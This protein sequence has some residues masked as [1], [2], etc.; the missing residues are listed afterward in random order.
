MLDEEFEDVGDEP[1][2]LEADEI[3]DELNGDE[4]DDGNPDADAGEPG[5]D[6]DPEGEQPQGNAKPAAPANAWDAALKAAGEMDEEPEGDDDEDDASGKPKSDA[7]KEKDGEQA[8]KP[9]AK[10]RYTIADANGDEYEIDW[11]KGAKISFKGDGKQVQVQSLDELVDL[12]QKGAAFDRVSSSAGQLK[13][14]VGTLEQQLDEQRTQ[15]EETLLK[16]CFDKEAFQAVRKSIAKYR[17]PDVR[18]AARK[19]RAHDADQERKKKDQSTEAQQKVDEFWDGIRSEYREQITAEDS[20]FPLLDEDDEGAV[21]ELFYGAIESR[22]NSVLAQAKAKNLERPEADR[23]SDEDLMKFAEKKALEAANSE[24]LKAAMKKI[25]DKYER[26]AGGKGSRGKTR[27]VPR[28]AREEVR[29]HNQRTRTKVR[30][31]SEHRGVR[32]AGTPPSTLRDTLRET[33]QTYSGHMDRISSEF[34]RLR[35]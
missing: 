26:K 7:T 13:S 18:E 32:R 33:P 1:D 11:P 6:D 19:A 17:D 21:I 28:E 3:D 29:S 30:R 14:Q 8:P 10:P 25:H 24:T 20:E 2:D 34:N 12:A 31:R 16:I 27:R 9:A 23:Y 5:D 4:L 15:F 35:K 22:F